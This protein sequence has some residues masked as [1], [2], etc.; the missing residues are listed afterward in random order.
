MDTAVFYS[1]TK[2]SI[3]YGELHEN[4]LNVCEEAMRL[5]LN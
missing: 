5:G 3:D 4:F 2:G 1:T